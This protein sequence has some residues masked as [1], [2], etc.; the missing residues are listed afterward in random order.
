[1]KNLTLLLLLLPSIIFS[2]IQIGEDIDGEDENDWSGFSNCL[3]A[4]GSI[5]AIGAIRNDGSGTV[6][7]S[8]HVRVYENLSGTWTQIGEDIDGESTTELTGYSVSLSSDGSIVAI[9]ST[10]FN[11]INGLNSGRVRIFENVSG[12]W[13]QIGADIEGEGSEDNSGN[14]ISL[15]S[16]GNII[17]IGAE[18]NDGINGF[19]SG[20]VRVYENIDSTWIQIGEDID[21]EQIASGSGFSVSLSSDGS[22]VAI[23][24]HYN[25]GNG[26]GS[27]HVRMYENQSGSWFQIG[28]DI[29]GEDST[30]Q[31]GYSVSLSSDGSIVAIGA[32][33]NQG[34]NGPRSGHV[35]IYENQSGSWIQIGQD[36]D[37]EASD[38]RLGSSISLSS[39][40]SII[41][42]GAPENNDNG[43]VAGH[44]RVY[45]NISG[46]WHQVGEDIDGEGAGDFS[47]FNVNLS[48]NGSTVAIGAYRNNGNGTN[49]GHTRVYDL[50]PLLSIEE[51]TNVSIELFPN[52]AK[53]QFNI[54][55]Q[56]GQKLKQV[57]IYNSLGQLVKTIET[58]NINISSLSPGIYYVEVITIQGKATKKLIIE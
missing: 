56:D 8:G 23:G 29:D 12:T 53:N 43:N 42:I 11:G 20:H 50:S 26:T 30:D 28:E 3:S 25:S 24:A 32:P 17:A 44:V 37:G 7:S 13:T 52:P 51:S 16:D 34:V 22:I 58:N 47:G 54:Q 46:T 41:A 27:G 6:S 31:S 19:N 14:S 36:I 35:R 45:M 15:S 4:D 18:N 49:S 48:S 57:N 55:L 33:Y 1:M 5:L 40:G 21:G 39:D 10:S 38:D 2:Q 9:G